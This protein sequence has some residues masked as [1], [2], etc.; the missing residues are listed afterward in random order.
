[1]ILPLPE[2]PWLPSEAA[3]L[4]Y[5]LSCHPELVQP[6]SGQSCTYTHRPLSIYYK[7][8]MHPAVPVTQLPDTIF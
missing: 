7:K 6:C 1:M 5:V 3:E 4:A 8:H 2:N